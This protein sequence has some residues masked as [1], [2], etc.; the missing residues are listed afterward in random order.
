MATWDPNDYSQNASQQQKWARELMGKLA[1]KG[2]EQVLDIGCGDGRITAELAAQV[3]EGSVIGVDA[4]P[5]MI[6]FAARHH[7]PSEIRNLTFLVADARKLDFFEQF[8]VVFS[9]A[10]LHWVY[11]HKPI[12]AGIFAALKPGGRMLVQMGGK[13]CADDVLA[14]IGEM[15]QEP[16]WSRYFQDFTFRYGFHGPVEYRQWLI[17]A[18]LEP[19]RIDHIEKDMVHPGR[20][21]FAGWIRTT[22]TPFLEAVDAAERAVFLDELVDRYI[23]QHP[24][25]AEGFV[26]VRMYRL[27]VDARRAVQ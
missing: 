23:A 17:D 12:L 16:R 18:G 26:H 3:P 15:Q 11:D 2:H 8:D 27:E 1:L 21:G 5:Q 4:S 19:V 13:G 24:I 20:E 10:A 9:N 25:D 14:V 6:D 7:P 22:W